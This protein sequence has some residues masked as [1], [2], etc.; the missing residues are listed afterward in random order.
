VDDLADAIVFVLENLNASDL[1]ELANVGTG[2]DIT[3]QE[4]AAQIADVVAYDGPVHWDTSRP[5]GTPQKLLDVSRLTG[6]GWAARTDLRTGL[7]WT[8]RW[9]LQN[10]GRARG[11]A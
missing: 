10:R 5:N 4:L 11:T 2:R 6:L 9:F 7:E 8:Y 1:G 3:I